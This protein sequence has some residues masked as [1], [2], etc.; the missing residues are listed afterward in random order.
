MC[1]K[2]SPCSAI[3]AFTLFP[4]CDARFLCH[5]NGPLGKILS[6]C[7]AQENREMYP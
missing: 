4:M 6:I 3:Y 7:L 5:G 2:C 1:Q